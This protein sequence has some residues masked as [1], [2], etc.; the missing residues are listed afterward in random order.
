M[1]SANPITNFI[2]KVKLDFGQAPVGEPTERPDWYPTYQALMDRGMDSDTAAAY[3]ANFGAESGYSPYAFNEKGGGRGAVGISQMRGLRLEEL[4]RM[5]A[6]RGVDRWNEDVQYDHIY[7]EYAR[8]DRNVGFIQN[9]L[10]GV[11]DPVERARLVRDLNLRPGVDP[12]GHATTARD[13]EEIATY[14][15]NQDADDAYRAQ[16]KVSRNRPLLS[17][18]QDANDKADMITKFTMG[19]DGESRGLSMGTDVP[20]AET[21]RAGPSAGSASGPPP[22]SQPEVERGGGGFNDLVDQFSSTLFPNADDPREKLGEMLGGLG[23]GLSQMSHGQPVNLQDYFSGI[24]AQKQSIIDSSRKAAM[25]KID[26][27]IRRTHAS[28]A[29]SNAETAAGTLSLNRQKA[30]AEGLGGDI[31]TFTE[32]QLKGLVDGNPQLAP[33][34]EM[35][36]HANPDVRKEGV[37]GLREGILAGINAKPGTSKAYG[38]LMEALTENR[39]I[40]EIADIVA[41]GGIKPSDVSAAYR[42][43]GRSPSSFATDLDRY[44]H[45]DQEERDL[46][47][48]VWLAQSG[49]D[50]TPKQA[51]NREKKDIYVEEFGDNAVNA[52]TIWSNLDDME[53]TTYAMIEAGTETGPFNEAY[54]HIA[55][56]IRQIF[57]PAASGF[58]TN[59][60]GDPNLFN[61]MDQ[62][63]KSLA[64]LI[65]QPLMQGG[66]S[67]SD[68]E[69][70]SMLQ[71]LANGG[72]T[73]EVRLEIIQK[74]K[75]EAVI[76]Q[77]TSSEYGKRMA[78]RED[79]EATDV[80]TVLRQEAAKAM[81]EISKTSQAFVGVTNHGNKKLPGFSY[82][83]TMS[84]KQQT[85]LI[86]PRLTQAQFDAYQEAIPMT[87]SGMRMW[88]KLGEGGKVTYMATD[89]DGNSQEIKFRE[90]AE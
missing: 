37:R 90:D 23:I 6:E 38:K 17:F 28:A 47:Q 34:I 85:K 45:A 64:L 87:K 72:T 75:A 59:Y 78:G 61:K 24:A 30:E 57:G 7:T 20:I 27:D 71:T 80:R 4:E 2:D 36:S 81:H 48:R 50:E 8:N 41:E 62:S 26:A 32:E 82:Y 76:S 16:D 11:T 65:A 58:L 74:L 31:P 9:A 55:N 33:F 88:A 79:S 54:V 66:G 1:A 84:V 56:G 29:S 46:M 77:L 14:L 53:R 86:A 83:G 68:G 52:A 21:G 42:D 43:M 73:H 44:R 22:G 60:M 3:T 63:E 39:P 51:Y 12:I 89:R 15:G 10:K 5:A 67:I 70:K 49:K 19:I 25:D 18:A 13:A 69:R 35:M 40:G